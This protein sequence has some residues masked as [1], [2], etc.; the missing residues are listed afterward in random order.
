MKVAGWSEAH[1][2]DL[3]PHNPLGPVCTAATVPSRRGG[4]QLRVARDAGSPKPSLGFDNSDFFPVQPRLDGA[5]YPVGDLP[6]LGVE[7]NEEAVRGGEPALL[8]SA[9]SQAPRWICHEL[10][11]P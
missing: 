9:A 5:D 10:V 4:A 11:I 2:V 7:V 1:Y 3:M 8:G 6:G